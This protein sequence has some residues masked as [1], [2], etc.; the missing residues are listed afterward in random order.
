MNEVKVLLVRSGMFSLK[1]NTKRTIFFKITSCPYWIIDKKISRSFNIIFLHSFYKV[2]VW[3]RECSKLE[4][5]SNLASWCK[6]Y[7]YW[8]L[9]I[10]EICHYLTSEDKALRTT[11]FSKLGQLKSKD[12]FCKKWWKKIFISASLGG[13]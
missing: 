1:Q 11:W 3:S 8:M 10:L 13:Y 7:F 5:S 12:V 2:V 6:Q 4:I 9:K